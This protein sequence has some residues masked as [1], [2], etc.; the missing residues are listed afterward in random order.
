MDND[1]NTYTAGVWL[2]ASKTAATLRH[3]KSDASG[4][5]IG[6]YFYDAEL[7]V[8]IDFAKIDGLVWAVW[9][10]CKSIHGTATGQFSGGALRYGLSTQV[11][12]N[13]DRAVQQAL[14]AAAQNVTDDKRRRSLHD[15]RRGAIKK[16]RH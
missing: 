4:G 6:G 8:F 9:K 15:E 11:N 14:A 1:V 16:R 13:L 7:K 12:K 10:G 3:H 2:P 5:E